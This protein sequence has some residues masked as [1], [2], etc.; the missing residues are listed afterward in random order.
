MRVIYS[1]SAIKSIASIPNVAR[2]R[3]RVG[4]E[5]LPTG[6]VKKLKGFSSAYRL[7]IGD[8]RIL[9]DWSE[10]LISITNILPRGSAYKE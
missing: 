5:K 4:I 2:E 9:F 7:R 1:K 8:Y 3:I 10:D 6:D